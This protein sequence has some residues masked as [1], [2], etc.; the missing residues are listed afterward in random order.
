MIRM[1]SFYEENNNWSAVEPPVCLQAVSAANEHTE[2]IYM[3]IMRNLGRNSLLPVRVDAILQT[4][5]MM[6]RNC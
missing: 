4:D 5:A 6:W 2:F 1:E 3:N